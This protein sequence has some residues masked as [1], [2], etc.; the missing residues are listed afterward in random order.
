[1]L[2]GVLRFTAKTRGEIFFHCGDELG[3]AGDG[4][5]GALSIPTLAATRSKLRVVAR[6]NGA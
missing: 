6:P 4:I 5:G 2:Y 3:E 1:V